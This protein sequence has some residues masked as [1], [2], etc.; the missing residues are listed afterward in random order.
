M[1]S[2]KR[3]GF[4]LKR[5]IIRAAVD[6]G[7]DPV[8]LEA[9]VIT[10]S[11]GDTYSMRYEPGWRW[12][13]PDMEISRYAGFIGA[14][15][16]TV[17]MGMATSWGLMHIMGTV[18]YEL[19]FYGWFAELTVPEVG[20]KYGCMHLLKKMNRY[21]SDPETAYAAYNSGSPKYKNQKNVDRFMKIYREIT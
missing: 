13:P 17:K 16:P 18:A 1:P 15:F 5:K 14:S 11:Y 21:G 2:K 19:E 6:H 4:G 3:I 10:E 7:I 12:Y 20:L 9:I 8:F